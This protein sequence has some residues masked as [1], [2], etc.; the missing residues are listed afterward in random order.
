MGSGRTLCLS[1]PEVDKVLPYHVLAGFEVYISH[2]PV[3][4]GHHF[5]IPDTRWL[6][7]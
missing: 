7:S 2:I 1:C 5:L 3:C 6:T 4:A